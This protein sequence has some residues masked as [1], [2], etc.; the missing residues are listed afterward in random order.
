MP[1]YSEQF[2]TTDMTVFDALLAPVL[3]FVDD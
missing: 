1:T 2:S 3:A